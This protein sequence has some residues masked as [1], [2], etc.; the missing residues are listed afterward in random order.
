MKFRRLFRSV[1]IPQD[2]VILITGIGNVLFAYS[3]KA[4]R[5][6][7]T[8]RNGKTVRVALPLGTDLQ[9]GKD[10]LMTRKSWVLAKINELERR[11]S[12][13][14]LADDLDGRD[15]A[16]ELLSRLQELSYKHGFMYKKVRVRKMSSRWGSCSPVN[17]I[18]LN[19][20]LAC[21]P[22]EIRDYVILHELVHT[23]YKNHQKK[24]WSTLN[25][26]LEGR[27]SKAFQKD[28]KGY[29]LHT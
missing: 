7:I 12:I 16:G 23:R 18:S 10:F 28:L 11:K 15:V 4:K 20:Y 5:M 19:Y 21:L 9:H 22:G 29:D 3:Q 8:I 17:N 6:N 25:T 13:K 27:D 24:F 26:C 14:L 2:R 1:E